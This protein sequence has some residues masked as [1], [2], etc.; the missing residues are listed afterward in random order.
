M[1]WIPLAAT[2]ALVAAA[3]PAL[4]Q[5]DASVTIEAPAEC[6]ETTFC[7]EVAEGSLDEIEPGDDVEI[8]FRN[9]ASAEHNLW[10]ADLADVT[11]GDGSEPED[12]LNGTEQIAEGEEATV[13]VTAP[14]GE[15]LYLWCDVPGHEQGGMYIEAPYESEASGGQQS[16]AVGPAALAA[17]LGAAALAVRRRR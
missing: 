17:V 10:V 11:P 4:A 9:Q 5:A 8:T 6:Q 2:V 14:D 16:P 3:A 1:R 7:Y 15:G 13:T 12:G